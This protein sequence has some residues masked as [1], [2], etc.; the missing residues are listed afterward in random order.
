VAGGAL[1][2]R[3]GGLPPREAWAV[4]FA[5]NSRGEMEIILGLLALEAGIIGQELFVALVIMAIA[6]SMMSGPMMRL[7]LRRPRPRHLPE[8]LTA[9][10]FI[11]DLEAGSPREAIGK[12][13]AAAGESVGL[14]AETIEAAAWAREETMSTGIG[15]GVAL[16]HARLPGLRAPAVV[17]AISPAGVDFDAPDDKL[18]RVIFLIL[19][20]EEDAGAQLEIAADVARLFRNA[21]L[22]AAAC[23]CT[24]FTDFLGAI[25]SEDGDG[26]AH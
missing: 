1:G 23:R 14:D 8:L 5:V 16:P 12:L 4:G 18:A 3:W 22:R 10:L 15:N 26:R 25:K 13:A 24:R 21:R 11:P 20:P 7:V 17:A 6:T 2:A 19:T 9:R